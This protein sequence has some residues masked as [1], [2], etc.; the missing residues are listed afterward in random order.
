[1][2]NSSQEF[3][4]G[5]SSPRACPGA[6]GESPPQEGN[7]PEQISTDSYEEID[8]GVQVVEEVKATTSTSSRSASPPAVPAD[9]SATN[10][11]MANGRD[12]ESSGEQ[13]KHDVACKTARTN[14]LDAVADKSVASS[15]VGTSVL[16]VKN[17]VVQ[18]IALST[19]DSCYG[20]RKG[21]KRS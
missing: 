4:F 8:N 11:R 3:S 21:V 17:I 6:A 18:N 14:V 12:G 15:T 7:S 16:E 1:M 9:A 19:H 10:G 5:G 2:S 20:D 13:C